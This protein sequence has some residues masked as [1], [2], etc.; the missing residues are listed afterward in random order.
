MTSQPESLRPAKMAAPAAAAAPSAN[1]A[2]AGDLASAGNSDDKPAPQ[3]PAN[4][5]AKVGAK[6]GP[7]PAGSADVRLPP[8][9]PAHV[10][11]EKLSTR[12]VVKGDSL[13]RISRQIYGRGIRYTQIYAANTDQIRNPHLI[14]PGQVLVVPVGKPEP[15]AGTEKTPKKPEP[16]R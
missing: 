4:P 12:S 8:P 13:W 9:P 14:Y 7:K 5:G 1:A 6:V 3:S 10:V 11:I 15:V 2:P 16:A